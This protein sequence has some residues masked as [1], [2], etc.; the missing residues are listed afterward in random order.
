MNPV[1]DDEWYSVEVESRLNKKIDALQ[2]LIH[3]QSQL[4]H[5]L[6]AE[7]TALKTDL[8]QSKTVTHSQ[9]DRTHQL[10][11]ELHVLKQREV[12]L[13]LRSHLPTPF[14]KTGPTGVIRSPILTRLPPPP[15]PPPSPS[16]GKYTL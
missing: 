2:A 4:I 9:N 12:N 14:F 8:T 5:Q 3:Q 16:G 1:I 15:L 6:T 13:A 11:E 10:L 7:L